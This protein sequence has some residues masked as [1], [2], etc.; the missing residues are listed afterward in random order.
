MVVMSSQKNTL[1]FSKGHGMETENYLE[2]YGELAKLE[3]NWRANGSLIEQVVINII[4][5]NPSG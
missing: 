3:V 1:R 4:Q 5:E 2:E